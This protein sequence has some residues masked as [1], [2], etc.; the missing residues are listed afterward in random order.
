MVSKDREYRSF[1]MRTASDE[2]TVEGYAAMFNAE[3]VLYSIDG[4]DYKEE[5]APE[6]FRNAQMSDVVMNYNHTG[7]PVARTKN[8]TLSLEVDS[9]GL[10]VRANLGGTEEGR[11]LYE[12]IRGG[13]ID[14]MSFAF[15]VAEAAYNSEEHKRRITE[16][17]RVFDVAA[18]DIP[19]YD[20]TSISAR[21]YFEAEAEKEKMAEARAKQKKKIKVLLEV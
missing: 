21:S 7:K 10:K 9:V 17:K 5:I 15:T 6:A 8:G 11:K 2:M 1:E 19:A 12:E 4:V 18:V 20:A 13:Y 14:K 16:F 3:T